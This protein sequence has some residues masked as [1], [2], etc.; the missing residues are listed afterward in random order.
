MED[1]GEKLRALV[2]RLDYTGTY[3]NA[4]AALKETA[5]LKRLSLVCLAILH[6]VSLNDIRSLKN[7]FLQAPNSCVE[8]AGAAGISRAVTTT[9]QQL[10]TVQERCDHDL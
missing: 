6:F 9:R 3:A 4:N 5:T 1:G 7:H 10:A 2:L 8:H